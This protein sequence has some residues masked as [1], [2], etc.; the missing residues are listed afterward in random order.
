MDK[1]TWLSK[2]VAFKL[3]SGEEKEKSKIYSKYSGSRHK[4]ERT[5]V[6]LGDLL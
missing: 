1:L 3:G 5:R 4:K 2:I 6:G